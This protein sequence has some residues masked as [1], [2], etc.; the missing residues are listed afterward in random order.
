V[1]RT[2]QPSLSELIWKELQ[3][4]A[5]SRADAYSE[6]RRQWIACAFVDDASAVA[7]LAQIVGPRVGCSPGV[8]AAIVARQLRPRQYQ[9][10]LHEAPA[11]GQPYFTDVHGRSSF[12][13]HRDDRPRG[14]A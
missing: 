10:L 14:T 11:G 12:W 4:F 7:A 2:R 6:V 9:R 13:R 5:H 1:K 8:A 3:D